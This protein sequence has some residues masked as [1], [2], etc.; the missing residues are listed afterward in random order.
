VVLGIARSEPL[1]AGA[2]LVA[3]LTQYASFFSARRLVAFR[4][5][6]ALGY[7][8]VALVATA[9]VARAVYYQVRGRIRWRGRTI[10]IGATGRS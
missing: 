10:R 5:L 8:L 3:Y 9:N 2:G 6:P 7:P 4:A 1:L